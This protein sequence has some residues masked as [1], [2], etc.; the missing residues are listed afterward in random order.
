MCKAL[1]RIKGFISL[2]NGENQGWWVWKFGRRQVW[3]RGL[4]PDF[5]GLNVAC[6][7]VEIY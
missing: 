5:A 3:G 1:E 7:G 4:S 2:G 6:E